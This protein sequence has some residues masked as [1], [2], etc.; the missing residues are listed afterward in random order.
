MSPMIDWRHYVGDG[1]D[2]RDIYPAFNLREQSWLR[3]DHIG[4]K[5]RK[6]PARVREQKFGFAIAR[7]I[8]AWAQHVKD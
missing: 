7:P 8:G 5:K 4:I 6:T 2:R 3:D 1:E